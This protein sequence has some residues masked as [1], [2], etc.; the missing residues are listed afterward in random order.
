MRGCGG[1]GGVAYDA[2]ILRNLDDVLSGWQGSGLD[3]TSAERVALRLC[4][5]RLLAPVVDTRCWHLLWTSVASCGWVNPATIFAQ[6]VEPFLARTF[7]K[8]NTRFV[9]NLLY[10]YIWR[11]CC[12]IAFEF[13]VA[14]PSTTKKFIHI[15]FHPVCPLIVD[16]CCGHMLCCSGGKLYGG[17]SNYNF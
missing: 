5:H 10:S 7:S 3:Q 15:D 9:W 1:E 2:N 4:G 8:L 16:T 14:L 13:V 6:P 11:Q 12:Q 17:Q